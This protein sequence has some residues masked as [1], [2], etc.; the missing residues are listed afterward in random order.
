ML[1]LTTEF[2]DVPHTWDFTLRYQD[3]VQEISHYAGL[4][5]HGP[6]QFD[7]VMQFFR[8]WYGLC[9]ITAT[10][11]GVEISLEDIY[12]GKWRLIK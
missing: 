2:F 3:Q 9:E 11:D 8:S 6:T 4:V 10:C 12:N 7:M 5:K 1:T